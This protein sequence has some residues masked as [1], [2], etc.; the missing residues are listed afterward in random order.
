MNAINKPNLEIPYQQLNEQHSKVLYIPL[1]LAL[2]DDNDENDSA[3]G[4]AGAAAAAATALDK[5]NNTGVALRSNLLEAPRYTDEAFV[6][7]KR[8]AAA[9]ASAVDVANI[10]LVA[11][12]SLFCIVV[13]LYAIYYFVILRERHK[14]IVRQPNFI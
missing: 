7:G 14:I 2:K 13:L 10:I 8:S 3:A 9:A 11:L 5:I 4:V 12:L 6:L 1:K